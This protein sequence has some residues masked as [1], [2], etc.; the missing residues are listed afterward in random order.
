MI[1]VSVEVRGGRGTV[2]FRGEVRAESIERAVQV[3]NARY[4][5]CEVR[6][7]FPIEPGAFFGEDVAPAA[8]MVRD[9]SERGAVS[10]VG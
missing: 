3:T 2:R 4:P 8:Q 6:M 1:Q 7:V 9:A 5:G 10:D